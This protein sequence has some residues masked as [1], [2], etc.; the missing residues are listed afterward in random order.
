MC[1]VSASESAPSVLLPPPTLSTTLLSA[2]PTL[3]VIKK[4]L[5]LKALGERADVTPEEFWWCRPSVWIVECVWEG[6]KCTSADMLF[7][8]KGAS[9]LTP[10]FFFFCFAQQLIGS[11]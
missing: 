1:V 2:L 3:V 4:K 10:F 7:V 11:A 8:E 6:S 5:P 9:P